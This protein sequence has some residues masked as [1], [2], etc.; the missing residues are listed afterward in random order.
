VVRYD[1]DK[2]TIEQ[3][4]YGT[5]GNLGLHNLAQLDRDGIPISFRNFDRNGKEETGSDFVVNQ[6]TGKPETREGSLAWEV[7]HDDHGNWTERQCWFTPADGSARVLV[8]VLH[9]VIVYR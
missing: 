5:E 4:A 8:R 7:T 1:D 6:N 2:N 3:W 9:Q